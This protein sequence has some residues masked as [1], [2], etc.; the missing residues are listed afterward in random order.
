MAGSIPTGVV[1]LMFTDIQD[2]TSLW[3]RMG[4]GFRPVLEQHNQI[5]SERVRRWGG[6]EIKSHGDSFMVAFERGTD[7]VHCAVE[8]QRALVEQPWPPEV[9]ELRIRIG[10]HTG[11]PFLGYDSAG[12]A[13]YFGPVVNRAARIADAGHGG[14]I[15]VSTA[16]RDTVQGALT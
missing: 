13:D 14:Q 3:E 16:T 12:R 11:E 8:T 10:M 15:V 7:A 6:C 5:I 9:G 2:S 4:D 1:T